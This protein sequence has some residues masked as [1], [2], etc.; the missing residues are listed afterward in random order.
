MYIYCILLRKKHTVSFNSDSLNNHFNIYQQTR[1]DV[2][3]KPNVLNVKM[4][5]DTELHDIPEFLNKFFDSAT[6]VS[7]FRITC[8]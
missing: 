1:G 3:N 4:L 7:F 2:L 6:A 5:S 8:Q